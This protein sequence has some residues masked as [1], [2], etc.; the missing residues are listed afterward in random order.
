MGEEIEKEAG[1]EASEIIEETP[2][3]ITSLKLQIEDM[4][5]KVSEYEDLAKRTR[6]EAENM[7][8]R[9]EKEKRDIIRFANKNLFM[10]MLNF[11]DDFERAIKLKPEN[12]GLE[13]FYKGVEM[14]YKGFTNFLQDNGVKELQVL[15]AEFDP[16]IHEAISL[17]EDEK[18][19]KEIVIEVYSKGFTLN[20]DLLRPPKVRIGKPVMKQG[21]VE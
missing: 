19:D 6:A 11:M 17:D 16:N 5:A 9:M 3:E 18:Y 21:N 12:T 2:D 14:I 8:K 7:R 1:D 20:D 10:N 4:T 13:D 15:H